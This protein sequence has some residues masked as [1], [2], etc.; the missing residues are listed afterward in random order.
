MKDMYEKI[1]MTSLAF[2]LGLTIM[3]ASPDVIGGLTLMAGGCL[4]I[5]ALIGSLTERIGRE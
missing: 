2:G 4:A 5:A 1:V 3:K